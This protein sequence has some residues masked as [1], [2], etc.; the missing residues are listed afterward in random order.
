M[1]DIEISGI[2][3]SYG[4]KAVLDGASLSAEGGAI[5]GIVGEN[6]TGKST[7][8]KVLG[9]VLRA[10]GGTFTVRGTELFSSPRELAR[11]VGYLPQGT[12][13]VSELTARENLMLWYSKSALAEALEAGVLAELGIR[14]FLNVRASRLSGG[15]KKRLAIGCAMASS[16]EVMLLDEPT[17]SL[18]LA[19]KGSILEW[20][21]DFCARGG[22]VILT[23]HDPA[24]LD[25][26][27]EV[28]ILRAGALRRY[29]YD[30]DIGRLIKT[31][32]DG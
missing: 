7:L 11:R 18:D 27:T 31:L 12:P 4:K 13:L 32:K 23:S 25:A 29:D 9:G 2:K 14:E 10:D 3:K 21:A 5:I 20:M 30:G 1:A 8:L 26:C 24:E 15:M 17:A 28:C 16:P 6:G 22:T 19:A